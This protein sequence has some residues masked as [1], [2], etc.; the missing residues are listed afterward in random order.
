MCVFLFCRMKI[1][2]ARLQLAFAMRIRFETL[3]HDLLANDS[4]TLSFDFYA[5]IQ[6][7]LSR[8]KGF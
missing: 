7:S 8:H 4:V 6:T 5:A 1:L 2:N 3:P